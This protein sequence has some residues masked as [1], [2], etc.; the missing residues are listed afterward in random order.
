[1]TYDKATARRSLDTGGGGGQQQWHLRAKEGVVGEGAPLSSPIDGTRSLYGAVSG[2]CRSQFNN[3]CTRHLP[4]KYNVLCEALAISSSR[5]PCP[6]LA[7]FFTGSS[8]LSLS[9]YAA[10]RNG[11]ADNRSPQK[12]H[13]T[14][15]AVLATG[16]IVQSTGPMN[17]K[18]RVSYPYSRI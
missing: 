12:T 3:A 16:T 17:T 7:F 6:C 5:G 13:G 14:G 2:I 11:Q 18:A 4:T 10:E 8:S 15:R 9:K 1:M